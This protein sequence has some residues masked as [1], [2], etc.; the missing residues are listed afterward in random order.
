MKMHGPL[1][2]FLGKNYNL[3]ILQQ[4]YVYYENQNIIN[5]KYTFMILKRKTQHMDYVVNTLDI[6]IQ[7]VQLVD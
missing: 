7:Q 4:G 5:T 2:W 3:I 1:Y 6:R